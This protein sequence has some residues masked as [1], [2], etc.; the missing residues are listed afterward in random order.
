MLQLVTSVHKFVQI[1]YSIQLVQLFSFTLALT[2]CSNP[3]EGLRAEHGRLEIAQFEINLLAVQKVL[4]KNDKFEM[5][6]TI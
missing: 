6:V 1:S 2:K 3:Y 4:Y 5:T